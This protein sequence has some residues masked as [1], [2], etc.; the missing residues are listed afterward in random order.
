MKKF[1]GILLFVFLVGC[2]QEVDDTT[3][4]KQLEDNQI[5]EDTGEQLLTPE[6]F[7]KQFNE[8]SSD[9]IREDT[10]LIRDIPI[11]EGAE[12]DSFQIDFNENTFLVGI[13]DD[14]NEVSSVMVSM[15]EDGS[16]EINHGMVETMIRIFSST[17]TDDEL[18]N[19]MEK[20][21]FLT[22]YDVLMEQIGHTYFTFVGDIQ[23]SMN[24]SMTDEGYV[25]CILNIDKDIN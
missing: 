22:E 14:N 2:S 13:V 11:E 21:Q 16:G 9:L 6:I 24:Y 10:F 15:V 5:E 4:L 23:Y 8:L 12:N 7:E 18:N 20:L 17:L 3:L 19:V 25:R 1:L